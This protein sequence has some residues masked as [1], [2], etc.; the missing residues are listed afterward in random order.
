MA[1]V[2][3]LDEW[4]RARRPGG[5]RLEDAVT[6][7][8][9]AVRERYRERAPDWLATEVL[10]VQGCISLG[11]LDDAAARTE[12]LLARLAHPSIRA[13]TAGR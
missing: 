3:R 8:D 1:M 11:L 4:L 7:L 5:D 12:R 2:V 10:A 6:R 9:E 13:R